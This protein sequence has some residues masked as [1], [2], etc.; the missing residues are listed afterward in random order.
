MRP[1]AGEFVGWRPLGGSRGAQQVP[2]LRCA[3]VGMTIQWRLKYEREGEPI[4]ARPLKRQRPEVSGRCQVE[5]SLFCYA[6]DAG[7]NPSQPLMGVTF[8]CR[9]AFFGCP[10][11]SM[12]LRSA[13]WLLTIRTRTS[14]LCCSPK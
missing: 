7:T 8:R 3:S 6:A 1:F 12:I 5:D 2:P 10:H 14:V 11:S 13:L 4:K 9:A